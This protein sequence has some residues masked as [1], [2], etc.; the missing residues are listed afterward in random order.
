MPWHPIQSCESHCSVRDEPE[1]PQPRS[2][3]K[4]ATWCENVRVPS[5]QMQIPGAGLAWLIGR[6]SHGAG[7]PPSP[8]RADGRVTAIWAER[9]VGRAASA[10]RKC[11]ASTKGFSN[12]SNRQPGKSQGYSALSEKCENISEIQWYVMKVGCL[13]KS[14]Q[15]SFVCL[16]K[17]KSTKVEG[18]PQQNMS[19]SQ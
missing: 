13:S 3:A 4:L 6:V 7:A 19:T 1:K 10:N 11:S 9:R 17:K 14:M 8:P 15:E 12:V 16:L 18:R 5:G 2:A